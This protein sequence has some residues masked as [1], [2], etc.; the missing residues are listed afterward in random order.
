MLL[1]QRVTRNFTMD[2]HLNFN[3]VVTKPEEAHFSFR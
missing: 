2:S 1:N 3:P